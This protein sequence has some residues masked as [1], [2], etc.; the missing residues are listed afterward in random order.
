MPRV[1]VQAMSTELRLASWQSVPVERTRRIGALKP[2]SGG[3]SAEVPSARVSARS[4]ALLSVLLIHVA[5][6]A[7]LFAHSVAEPLPLE[8]EPP[9]L[10]VSLVSEPDPAP[11][12]V[13]LLPEPPKPEPVVQKSAPKPK[14]KP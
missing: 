12:V 9:P 13:P 7:M 4:V 14:P 10:M 8:K 5:V 11:E 1:E 2:A 3:S 6:F